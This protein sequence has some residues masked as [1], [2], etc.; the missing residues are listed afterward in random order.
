MQLHFN[1]PKQSQTSKLKIIYLE[2]NFR[3]L[4]LLH[5]FGLM[6]ETVCEANTNQILTK[7]Y[8]LV[9]PSKICERQPLKNL[10][11]CLNRSYPFKFF[12]GCLPQVL[13][14][15]FLNTLSN[16]KRVYATS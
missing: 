2:C 9:R 1:N 10:K 5:V 3:N 8:Y 11:V 15:P 16:I 4:K 12:E 6:D 7:G 14:G 13:L